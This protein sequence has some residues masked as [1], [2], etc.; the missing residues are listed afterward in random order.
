MLLRVTNSGGGIAHDIDLE[1]DH[2]LTNASGVEIRF[3]PQRGSP[4]IPVLMPEQS[5]SMLVDGHVQ[6]FGMEQKHQYSGKVRYRDGRGKHRRHT[7]V[8]DGEMF[9]GT[10][11][12]DREDLR[13]HYEVQKIPDALKKI[14]GELSRIR[15]TLESFPDPKG[16]E[17]G[18]DSNK[19]LNTPGAPSP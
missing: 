5:V 10:P 6:F 9:R 16:V 17:R 11:Y 13:T 8:L 15:A 18:A 2:P 14:E 3:S 4:E 7:F 12:Y 19:L 1:W